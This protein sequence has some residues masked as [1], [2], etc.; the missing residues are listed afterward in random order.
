M[1]DDKRRWETGDAHGEK[2]G[3][4]PSGKQIGAGIVG[5]LLLV[6]V[7]QNTDKTSVTL[8]LFDINSPLW[9][10]LAGSILL[11]VG[12]GYVLGSRRGSRKNR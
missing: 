9:M 12:V 2:D 7:L 10:V 8:L 11:S 3:F 1:A 4:K 6:F 5:L